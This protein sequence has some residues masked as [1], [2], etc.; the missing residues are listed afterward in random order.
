MHLKPF[1]LIALLLAAGGL[2]WWWV[3]DGGLIAVVVVV[4]LGA[5][6]FLALRG[7][8]SVKDQLDAQRSDKDSGD[9]PS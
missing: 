6:L 2:F 8:R 4:V 5:A 3:L 1:L 9:K 7:N